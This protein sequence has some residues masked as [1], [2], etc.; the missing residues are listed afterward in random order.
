VPTA[1]LAS[2]QEFQ[3][4][5]S[6]SVLS[7]RT[8]LPMLLTPGTQLSTTAVAAIEHLG[9]KQ[10]I[11]MGGPLAVSDAVEASLVAKTGVSVLRVAGKD[12]TD[13]SRELARFEVAASTHGMGWT[14]GH[15]VMVARG[16]GFTDGL[17]GAVLDSPHNSSTGPSSSARPLLLIESPTTVGSYQT[18]FLTLTGHGGIDGTPAKTVRALTVLGG[19]LAVST[20]SITAM[21]TDLTR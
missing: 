3:D 16:D 12:Y 13:T 2:G 20:A 17:A 15:R 4:A 11:L 7:Y 18:T 5:Q 10:V 14:P 1:I 19:P 9:I 8:R 21:Q 6:A